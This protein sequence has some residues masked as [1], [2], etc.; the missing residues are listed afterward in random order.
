MG[1]VRGTRRAFR[2]LTRARK[3]SRIVA[4]RPGGI[5]P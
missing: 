5:M 4:K 1:Y 2:E 3:R